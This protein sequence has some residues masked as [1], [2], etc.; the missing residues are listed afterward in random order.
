M[1]KF[2]N[3]TPAGLMVY[4]TGLPPVYLLST[5]SPAAALL[6]NCSSSTLLMLL[7]LLFII[8][9]FN[10]SSEPFFSN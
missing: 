2:F 4:F 5:L 3:M 7:P 6:R 10:S 9:A 1:S 8:C